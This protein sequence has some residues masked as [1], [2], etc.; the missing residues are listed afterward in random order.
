MDSG[1]GPSVWKHPKKPTTVC[2][3]WPKSRRQLHVAYTALNAGEEE[4]Q[5]GVLL[6]FGQSSKFRRDCTRGDYRK[7]YGTEELVSDR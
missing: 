7:Q 2:L 6:L 3:S 5:D 1:C 4:R